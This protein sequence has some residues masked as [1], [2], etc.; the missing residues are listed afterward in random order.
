MGLPVPP[1]CSQACTL[2]SVSPA[3]LVENVGVPG[4]NTPSVTHDE[5][6]A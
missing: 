1:E 5:P 4:P 2:V 3:S 6:S